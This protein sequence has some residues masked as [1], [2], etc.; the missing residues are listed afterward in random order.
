MERA[1][2]R[3]LAATAGLVDEELELTRAERAADDAVVLTFRAGR[4]HLWMRCPEEGAVETLSLQRDGSLPVAARLSEV[5]RGGPLEVLAYRPG[6]CLTLRQ[7]TQRGPRVLKAYP[8]ERF[9]PA[10]QWHVT[11]ALAV[12]GS[13]LRVPPLTGRDD[14]LAC[15][16]MLDLGRTPL[17][18][19]H[20][21][22]GWF[23]RVGRAL[24]GFQGMRPDIRLP[25]RDLGDEL[26]GL[27]RARREAGFLAGGLPP[28]WEL[29]RA[30]L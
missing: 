21:S 8:R 4:G 5:A 18:L 15:V 20:L 24:R 7:D 10:V 25:E 22:A 27:D 13:P 1:L 6:R 28:G 2:A 3:A 19:E 17:A 14:A 23:A 29:A 26:A 11:A 16:T 12:E 30:K 9:E